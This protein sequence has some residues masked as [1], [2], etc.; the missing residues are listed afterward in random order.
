MSRYYL[1]RFC[2]NLGVCSWEW[3]TVS[4]G[5]GPRLWVEQVLE[6]SSCGIATDPCECDHGTDATV[7]QMLENLR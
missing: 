7:E 3:R 6:Q 4:R 1:Y 2:T 5:S